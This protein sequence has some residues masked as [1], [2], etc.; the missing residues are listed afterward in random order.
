MPFRKNIP[1]LLTLANLACGA[2]AVIF[3]LQND[4]SHAGVLLLFLA[5]IFD[6]LDGAVAR[7]LGVSNALGQQLDSLADVVSFGLAPT[8]VAFSLAESLSDSR[9]HFVCYLALLN[10]CCA[11]WRLAHFNIS[12]DQKND[13]SGMPSPANGL[14]WAGIAAVAWETDQ[15]LGLQNVWIVVALILLSS[16]LMISKVRMFSFK[17]KPGGLSNN[18]IPFLYIGSIILLPFITWL[19]FDSLLLCVPLAVLWYVVLST[20]Q[21]FA[22]RH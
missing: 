16:W 22:L 4:Y 14:L 17:L 1:N 7:S 19:C 20:V 5:A 3:I 18:K 11:A 13:F 9:Q 2:L 10:V 12:T 15:Q 21:H 6:V 8:V